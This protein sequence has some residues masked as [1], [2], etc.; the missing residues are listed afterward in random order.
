MLFNKNTRKI[1]AGLFA[2]WAVDYWEILE[3]FLSF[4]FAKESYLNK[5]CD[6]IFNALGYYSGRK[7]SE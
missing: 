3:L 1:G 7:W 6:L 5:T 4:K 2:H